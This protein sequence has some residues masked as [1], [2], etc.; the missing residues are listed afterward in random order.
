MH[1]SSISSPFPSFFHLSLLFISIR[2]GGMGKNSRDSRC[3]P[4]P[5]TNA[6]ALPTGSKYFNYGERI[7]RDYYVQ[8]LLILRVAEQAC[9]RPV[10]I[11]PN[12]ANVAYVNRVNARQQLREVRLVI[13]RFRDRSFISDISSRYPPI[14]LSHR[15][16][17]FE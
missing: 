16:S 13:A 15:R 6:T 10:Q 5:Q 2:R 17:S 4:L 3:F 8:I 9:N 12:R 14:I 7:F 11:C 1:F